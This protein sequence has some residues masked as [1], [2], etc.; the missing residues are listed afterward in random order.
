MGRVIV[1]MGVAF[2][3]GGCF[4]TGFDE[5]ANSL[6][7]GDLDGGGH[8]HGDGDGD[9]DVGDGD[10]G[11]GDV[12]DGDGDAVVDAAVGDGDGDDS[13]ASV[14]DG[15]GD[16]DGDACDDSGSDCTECAAP[17]IFCIG[18]LEVRCS[19]ALEATTRTCGT[20]DNVC[21]VAECKEGT[22]CGVRPVEGDLPC[23]GDLFCNAPGTCANGSCVHGDAIVDC[24]ELDGP[25][26][27]GTCN[28]T[29]DKCEAKP[30]NPGE[31][32]GDGASCESGVCRATQC[33]GYCSLSCAQGARNCQAVCEG[34]VECDVTCGASASCAID[35][36]A[37]E[38]G[39]TANCEPGSQCHVTC[40]PQQS[41]TVDCMD[42]SGCLL[43]CGDQ[44]LECGFTD[45]PDPIDCGGGLLACGRICPPLP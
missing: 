29:K 15:D 28:E 25:C 44:G 21:V 41:C 13:D 34:A 9:G 10:V 35:C 7:E 43:Q 32:C 17:G 4:M 1:S 12:G 37:T 26:S 33:E 30:A 8:S 24:S 16:G 36:A 18:D 23:G 19:E 11:D 38:G 45:C 5:N 6:V 3:L 20:D 31:D 2:L 27:V 42:E 22:G 40:G 39:C 14:G